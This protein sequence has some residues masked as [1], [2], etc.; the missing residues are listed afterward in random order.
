MCTKQH[1]YKPVLAVFYISISGRMNPFKG[2][3]RF[4]AKTKHFNL[5]LKFNTKNLYLNIFSFSKTFL[6][7]FF[8]FFNFSCFI[9]RFLFKCES[10]EKSDIERTQC[11]HTYFCRRCT[12]RR[13][14][15]LSFSF[16]RVPHIYFQR[17]RQTQ[18]HRLEKTHK[19]LLI[20]S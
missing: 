4:T 8:C 18:T 10:N 3:S 7:F 11:Y 15:S 19:K 14:L 2:R 12:N 20:H 6:T 1:A 16:V 13:S 9:K 17:K 5:Q